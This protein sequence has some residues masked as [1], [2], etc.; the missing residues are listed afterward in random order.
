MEFIDH[1]GHIFS[2]PSYNEYPVGYEY[3]TNDYIFWINNEYTGRLSTETFY[4]K[5]IRPL[6][7]NST[8]NIDSCKYSNIEY[9]G[10]SKVPYKNPDLT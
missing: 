8:I 6:L 3:D 10:E 1:T 5:P 9:N 2:L 4:M 7:Y